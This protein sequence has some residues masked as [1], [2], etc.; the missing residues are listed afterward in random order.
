M[1]EQ[2]AQRYEIGSDEKVAQVMLY[3]Q[4]GFFWGDVIV[5]EAVRVSTWLR[6]NAAPVVVYLRNA[7]SLNLSATSKPESTFYKE[8][9]IFAD[10]IV[11]MHL[12]P[13]LKDG[14]DYDPTEPN[15]KLEQVTVVIGSFV[16]DGYMRISNLSSVDKYLS[17]TREEFTS[18]YD[19]SISNHMITG[20]GI[21]KVPFVLVRQTQVIYAKKD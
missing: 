2:Q 16:M 9:L 19:V 1:T 10:Q 4:T 18:L 12:I 6:S 21:M 15:R 5:K 20:L 13:P 8:M 3:T 7:H 11:G 14:L 17:V